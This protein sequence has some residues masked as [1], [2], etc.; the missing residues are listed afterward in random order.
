[1]YVEAICPLCF[2][3][4]V[5]AE[6]MRGAKYRCEECEEVF[7]VSRKAKRTSKKPPRP[8]EVQAADEP[9]EAADV[10]DVAEVLPEARLAD[11]SGKKKARS[12]DDEVLEIPDEAVQSGGSRGKR[13]ADA[14]RRR[15]YDDK[16]DRPQKRRRQ[17][18]DDRPSRREPRR[19]GVPVVLVIGLV[20]G[21]VMLLGGMLVL[22]AWWLWPA[23]TVEAPPPQ[24]QAPANNVAQNPPKVDPPRANPPQVEVPPAEPPKVE[25]PP[26]E[27]PGLWRVKADPP[28]LAVTLPAD[29]KTGIKAPGLTSLLTFPSGPSPCVALGANL[30]ANDER[31]VWNLQ[32][33]TMIGKVI[34]AVPTVNG[35]APVLS[36]D[37]SYLAFYEKPGTVGVWAVAPGKKVEIEVGAGG[38]LPDYTAFA[39]DRLLTLRRAGTGLQFQLWNLTTGKNELSFTPPGRISGIYR[40]AV[41][42]SP[43]GGYVAVASRETLLI[44]ELKTGSTVGRRAMPKWEVGRLATCAGLSFAPDGSELAALFFGSGAQPRLLCW[45]VATSNV[46]SDVTFPQAKPNPGVLSAYKGHV[47]DWLGNRRGWLV[48][49]YTMIDRTRAG[50]ATFLPQ[51]PVLGTPDPRHLVGP[52]HVVTLAAGA[53][54]NEKALAVTRFDPDK[55]GG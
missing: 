39:G 28:A 38:F 44:A 15:D 13:P 42:V 6:E 9:G 48:Y 37:G 52:D 19:S 36:P 54:P 17:D 32:T 23:K 47:I 43:G 26:G 2:K 24:A 27:A 12:D 14:K 53:K 7:I 31:Q 22:G 49:G 50:A 55:P 25:A 5:V 34:G 8:R 51:P 3:S 21:V 1:M 35:A 11:R 18:D 16:D 30:F 33:G 40:D 45:D 46:L 29:V 41:A 4:H 10:A 20:A